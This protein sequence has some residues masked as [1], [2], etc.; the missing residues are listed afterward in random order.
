MSWKKIGICALAGAAAALLTGCFSDPGP[1]ADEQAL[2]QE[3][4]SLRE[5]NGRLEME[6]EE[7]KRPGSDVVS[8]DKCFAEV[9]YEWAYTEDGWMLC[10]DCVYKEF[11][12]LGS[13]GIQKCQYCSSF[14]YLSDTYGTGYC[15]SCE[16]KYAGSCSICLEATAWKTEDGSFGLCK[17]CFQWIFSFEAAQDFVKQ[18]EGE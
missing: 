12:L 5:E 13:E 1:S 6:L 3:V 9:P 4:S 10:P 11:E 15:H 14:Y 18:Y 8:C 7:A 2:L 17:H 16:D